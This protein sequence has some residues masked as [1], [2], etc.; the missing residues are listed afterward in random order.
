M[1][2]TEG[3]DLDTAV[4]KEADISQKKWEKKKERKE[5]KRNRN[6]PEISWRV[7]AMV[8]MF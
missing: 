3:M 1:K 8:E 5:K 6:K 2:D 7:E 4:R